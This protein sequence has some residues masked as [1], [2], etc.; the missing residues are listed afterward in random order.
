M[1]RTN[2]IFILSTFLFIVQL[3]AADPDPVFA[4]HGL[5]VSANRLA[6][7]IGVKILEQGGNAV[8]A[9]VAT[10]FA[11]AVTHSQAGN[12]GGGGFMVAHLADGRTFTLDYRE[13]APAAAGRD[14]FLD[15]TG[16]VIEKLSISTHLASGV[17][18]SVDGLLT[19]WAD[20]GSGNI[21]RKQLLAPA[22]ALARRGYPI[23]RRYADH[24]N[25]QKDFFTG[26]PGTAAIFIRADGR[27]WQA[28]DLLVQQDLARTLQ[29]I[30]KNGRDGF[31][32]GPVADLIVAEMQRGGGLITHADLK[33]YQSHYREPLTGTFREYGILTMPPT[34][35]GGVLV[36]QMLNMLE[37][38]EIDSIG[39]NSSAYIHLL[40]EV[41]RRAYAD[42]AEHL[43]DPDFWDIPLDM[44]ISKDYARRRSASITSSEA[45]PSGE[46]GAGQTWPAE[47][48]ETTHYSVIDRAGNAV[49]VTTTLNFSFGSGITVDGAGFLLNN[50]MD[51]FSSKP[52]VPNAFGL[53]G[54][55]AN[56]IAPGKRMLSSM[57]PTI[58]LK[59]DQPYLLVG[60]PGGSTIITTV[61]QIILNVIVHKMDIQ[62][63]VAAPRIHS[64]WY[65]DVISAE[66]RSLSTDVVANLELLGHKVETH[67]WGYIGRANC[68]LVD[69]TGI[70]GGADPR[71]ENAAVGY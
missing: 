27:P 16:K 39:W 3:P 68:I 8:D 1:P 2:G 31:Y 10:G 58:V 18:G 37:N 20:Y 23:S 48:P 19:A 24:L 47:S 65:P 5:V 22:V 61:L 36:I 56:A 69:S 44:L 26:D 35:S 46:V 63:A 34:S 67:R 33:N 43:G 45:T 38:F 64:Q 60:A 13:Q 53:L 70:Y 17:P 55:E 29:L 42:R 32:T 49:S 71:G 4:E 30:V 9:A 66:I 15:S 25:S 52:G 7:E 14:M 11:L 40:T 28:G 51:D 62:E 41:E 57:T 12:I 50:E 54:N 6:S 21:S 59:N